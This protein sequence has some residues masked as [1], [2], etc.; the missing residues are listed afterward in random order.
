MRGRLGIP[1]TFV[2]SKSLAKRWFQGLRRSVPLS[3]GTCCRA[4]PCGGDTRTMRRAFARRILDE[5]GERGQRVDIQLIFRPSTRV[6]ATGLDADQGLRGT[7]AFSSLGRKA[8]TG[9]Q[10]GP[11]SDPNRDSGIIEHSTKEADATCCR[12]CVA[13]IRM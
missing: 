2:N 13:S 10:P 11:A 5:L 9:C 1:A 3:L 4:F 8:L 6:V 7:F 12:A